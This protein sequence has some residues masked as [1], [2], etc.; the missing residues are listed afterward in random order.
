MTTTPQSKSE[1][2]TAPLTRGAKG[3]EQ[4]SAFI[5]PHSSHFPCCNFC[6]KIVSFIMEYYLDKEGSL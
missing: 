2:L 6:E 3:A 5:I 4:N 1:I